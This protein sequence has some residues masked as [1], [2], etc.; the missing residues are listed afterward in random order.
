MA[1]IDAFFLEIRCIH[2]DLIY[3]HHPTHDLHF[4]EREDSS[5]YSFTCTLIK[6]GEK[7]LYRTI[8]HT[9]F[10]NRSMKEENS[11]QAN[12]IQ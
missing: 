4:K 6:F 11:L 7:Q 5:S 3:Q 8:N 10:H 12:L 9:V 2:I 1:I